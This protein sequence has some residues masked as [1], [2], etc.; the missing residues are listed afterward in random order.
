MEVKVLTAGQSFGELALI[1]NKPRAATIRC[2]QDT[3]FAVLS[4]QDYGKVLLK[5]DEA[6]INKIVDFLRGTP[7]FKNW[8]KIALSKLSYFFKKQTFLR[9]QIVFK[10][11]DLCKNVYIIFNG[12]FEIMKK[13]K[14]ERCY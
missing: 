1:Q 14:P 11:G 8:T 5:I 12:E 10:E 9:N 2:T 6:A 13:M 7:H 4:R 3:H